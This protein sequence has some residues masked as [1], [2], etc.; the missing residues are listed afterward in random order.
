MCD[1]WQVGAALVWVAL[2]AALNYL[3]GIGEPRH[4]VWD[5]SYYLT[6]IQRYRDGTAQFASHP[7]LGLM[8]LAAGEALWQDNRNLD[9]TA[10]GRDKQVSGDR[11]PENFSFTGE[12]VASGAFAVAGA[13]AFFALMLALTRC[14]LAAA[15][16][17]NLYVFENAFIVQFRAAQL[18]AFL[19]FFVICALWCLVVRVHNRGR[20]SRVLDFA[21]GMACGL[22]AMVKLNAGVL[23]LSG[24]MVVLWDARQRLVTAARAGAIMLTGGVLAV[25]AVLSLHVALAP[26]PPDSTSSAGQKDG[27]FVSANYS[28]YLRGKRPFSP[29]VVLAA[30]RDYGHFVSADFA[31]MSRSD[32]NSSNALQWPLHYKTINYRWDARAGQ[33]S[34]VQL[35]G[36]LFGWWVA[37]IAPLAAAGLLILQKLRP[38]AT[39]QPERRVLLTLL[40]VQYLAIM[41]L[42]LW[43]GTQRVMYLYHYFIGLV[44]AFCLVP[45]AWQEAADRW[46]G[47]RGRLEPVMTGGTFLL[48]ASFA[49]YAP[50]TFHRP[51]TQTQCEWR[52]LFQHVVDCRQ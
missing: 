25:I 11:L 6:S 13:V 12:R 46:P 20:G 24:V 18:D 21:F 10:L 47:L 22:A 45:L 1:R 23:A 28:D 9:T 29:T 43:L 8:L 52:N 38:C 39:T 30:A 4:P 51:L 35:T 50:L 32:P 2:L 27:R 16:L 44:V 3:V 5:E 7:P 15:L 36:N 14:V 17:A 40:L 33:T 49:F 26:H 31:G 34:Y 42:H 48:L 37:L 41:A 19:V